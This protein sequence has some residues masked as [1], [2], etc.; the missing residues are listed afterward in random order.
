MIFKTNTIFRD[1]NKFKVLFPR[2]VYNQLSKIYCLTLFGPMEYSL[3]FDTVK[4]DGP[5]YI[6]RDDRLQ[7]QKN[8]AFLSLKINFVLANSSYPDDA[9]F[10]LGFHCLPLPVWGFW[11]TNY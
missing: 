4:Q 9:A 5:L 1:R 10:H 3:K 2:I 7:F 6:L 8:I 11:S